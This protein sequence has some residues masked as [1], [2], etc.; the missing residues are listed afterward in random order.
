M[1]L[2]V[3]R[4]DSHDQD[5]SRHLF[6]LGGDDNSCRNVCHDLSGKTVVRVPSNNV[7]LCQEEV[8]SCTVLLSKMGEDVDTGQLANTQARPTA[9]SSDAEA[10]TE[11]RD[12]YD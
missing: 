2:V 8:L 5:Q 1:V 6:A 10:Q 9:N 11:D 3:G 4:N 7:V 12:A